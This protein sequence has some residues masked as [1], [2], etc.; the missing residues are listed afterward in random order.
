MWSFA[1]KRRWI[2]FLAIA[3]IV[4][5][6]LFNRWGYTQPLLYSVQFYRAMGSV[7]ASPEIH[8]YATAVNPAFIASA[9]S[10]QCAIGGEQRFLA[11]GWMEFSSTLVVPVQ[12]GALAIMVGQEGLPFSYEQQVVLTHGRKMGQDFSFG[13]SLGIRRTKASHFPATLFP[14]GAAGL[15][16][17]I[18]ESVS[19]S[20]SFHYFPMGSSTG[21]SQKDFSVFRCL[22][23]YSAS[24]KI[25]LVA[26]VSKQKA[27]PAAGTF[28]IQYQPHR[29]LGFT[30]GFSGSPSLFWFGLQL[31]LDSHWRLQLH[32]GYY[33]LVGVSNGMNLSYM[34]KEKQY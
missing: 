28:S 14:T 16:F 24:E 7:V 5:F 17:Q 6:F 22:L 3:L 33:P 15:V 20:L 30:A 9:S 10:L 21:Y 1:S 12:H 32:S 11:P 27:W 31:A 4:L 26:S 25:Q 8:P 29:Q 34:N 2:R 13:A 19:T 18:S 23:A